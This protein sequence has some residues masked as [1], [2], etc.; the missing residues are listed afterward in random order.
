MYSCMEKLVANSIS[1][2]CD[3]F[4]TCHSCIELTN[5]SGVILIFYP[6]LDVSHTVN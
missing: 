2:V 4:E 6:N 3:T 1:S 5:V